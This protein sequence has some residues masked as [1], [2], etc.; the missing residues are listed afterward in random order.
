MQSVND[1]HFQFASFF[2]SETLKPYAY[3][4]SKKLDEGHICLH[5]KDVPKELKQLP[6]FDI[7]KEPDPITEL[8]GE[9]LVTKRDGAKQPF[10]ESTK[11][12]AG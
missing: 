8:A 9:H 1:V 6:Y 2:K 3:L 7:D 4:V 5:L 10:I 11:I 12:I